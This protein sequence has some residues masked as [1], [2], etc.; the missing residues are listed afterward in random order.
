MIEG[1]VF[2]FSRENGMG[3]VKCSFLHW[4]KTLA[5]R[6]RSGVFLSGCVQ[7]NLS[8][9]FIPC[10]QTPWHLSRCN[11]LRSLAFLRCTRINWYIKLMRV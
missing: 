10:H 6:G 11:S 1:K 5:K 2:D 9:S 3:S 7:D 4:L 8:T